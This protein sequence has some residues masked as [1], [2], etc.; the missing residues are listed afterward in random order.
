MCAHARVCV[1]VFINIYIKITGRLSPEKNCKL[2]TI[3]YKRAVSP[4]L[5]SLPP[6]LPLGTSPEC[7]SADQLPGTGLGGGGAEQVEFH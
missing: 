4:P 7:C 5:A 2:K 6:C 3:L 1:C